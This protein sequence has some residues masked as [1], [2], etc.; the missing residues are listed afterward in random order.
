[1]PPLINAMI[2]GVEKAGTT[3]LLRYLSQHPKIDSHEVM[4]M[5]FFTV[6]KEYARGYE[7]A[8]KKYF[9]HHVKGNL[10][11][12]KSVGC[13]YYSKALSRLHEHNPRMK[14]ILILR[15]P[16]DRAYS[17]YLYACKMGR[18]DSESFEEAI[19]L[20]EKRR[21]TGDDFYIRYN[22]YLHRG[23]Y[24]EQIVRLFYLFP[25]DQ[26]KIILFEDFK[27]NPRRVVYELFDFLGVE[28]V[29][30]DISKKYNEGST[31]RSNFFLRVFLRNSL[32]SNVVRWF[33]PY[34]IRQ[35]IKLLIRE[36][37]NRAGATVQPMEKNTR[38]WL[39]E[40]YA[41]DIQ[42]VE[43]LLGIDLSRWKI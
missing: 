43:E 29:E 41:H 25:R 27:E 31:S 42:K 11:L 33:I 23:L 2:I 40:Y 36:N 9:K 13:I 5:S 30:V 37:K 39:V 8:Y 19:Q 3:S 15:N 1:M 12:A 4:E 35:K 34:E 7:S 24:S 21:G 22:S 26:I 6:D 17:A 14:L 28:P 32:F 16:V 20:E 10:L 18:E 38:K